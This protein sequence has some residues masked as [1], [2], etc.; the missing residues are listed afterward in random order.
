MPQIVTEPRT[1][2][3]W[4]DFIFDMVA[5]NPKGFRA[6]AATGPINT[7][8][9]D[10]A[11]AAGILDAYKPEGSARGNRKRA[12]RLRGIEELRKQRLLFPETDGIP[13]E[14]QHPRHRR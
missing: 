9:N 12:A 8:V 13:T 11:V 1:K 7:L 5:L 4:S 2:A 10:A 6:A 14:Y 3:Q